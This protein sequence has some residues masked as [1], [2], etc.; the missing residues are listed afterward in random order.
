MATTKEARNIV[1]IDDNDVTK[2][3]NVFETARP[4]RLEIEAYCMSTALRYGLAVPRV[5]DYGVNAEGKEYLVMERIHGTSVADPGL[6]L[7]LERVYYRLGESLAPVPAEYETFGWIVPGSHLGIQSSWPDFLTGHVERY[8]KGLQDR[9]KIDA[10]KA[11]EIVEIVGKQ[12]PVISRASLVH[13]DLKPLNL[14]IEKESERLVIL[15]WECA[16]IGDPLYDVGVLQSRYYRDERLSKGLLQGM[17][18][19]RPSREHCRTTSV[20]T[21]VNLV[22]TL[23]AY[24]ERAG[25]AY[26]ENLDSMI[27]NLNGPSPDFFAMQDIQIRKPYPEPSYL[28]D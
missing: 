18:G 8:A 3:A 22:D 19:G 14:M 2:I 10:T 21:L 11:K 26:W 25:L 16:M 15:D 20:Y 6:S 23:F 28:G 13:R 4:K 17:V 1:K 5:R 27:R 12:T 7:P 24:R 9:G